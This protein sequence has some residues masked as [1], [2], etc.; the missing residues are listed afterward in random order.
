M[1]LVIDLYELLANVIGDR[2]YE[3]LANVI[4]DRLV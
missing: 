1:L 2:L 4:G 3:L